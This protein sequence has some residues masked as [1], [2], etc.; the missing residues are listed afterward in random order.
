MGTRLNVRAICINIEAR[1]TQ[2][3]QD[4]SSMQSAIIPASIPEVTE[5]AQT[6]VLQPSIK[7]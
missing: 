5:H 2:V 7:D 4:L 1:N 3:L 6:R